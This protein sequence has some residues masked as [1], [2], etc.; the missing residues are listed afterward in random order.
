MYF[1]KLRNMCPFKT[2]VL[3]LLALIS[4]YALLRPESVTASSCNRRYFRSAIVVSIVVLHVDLLL[5][6]GYT[7]GAMQG[8]KNLY[9]LA[10]H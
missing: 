3:S 2:L 6:L 9:R 1:V 7:M 5:N 8:C 10:V 4:G